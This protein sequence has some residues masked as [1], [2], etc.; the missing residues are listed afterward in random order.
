MA[1]VEEYLRY[2]GVENIR[3][4]DIDFL[5]ELHSKH[6]LKIP[7]ENLDIRFGRRIEIS[8]EAF[9]EKIL[10]RKR[11]GFCYELN[12]AFAWLLEQLGFTLSRLSARVGR[13]SGGY[14]PEFDHLTLLVHLDEDYLAD[15]GFGTSS[16]YP[17]PLSGVPVESTI[18]PYRIDRRE[19]DT[20][21]YQTLEEGNWKDLYFFTLTPHTLAEYAGMCAYHQENPDSPFVRGTILCTKATATG[22]VW[23]RGDKFIEMT[24]AGQAE[25]E[26]D[27]PERDR[28][29]H[30]YFAI[31]VTE[32]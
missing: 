32:Q 5:R 8:E 16:L 11:G 3:Q 24:A 10:R 2:I 27:I 26:I 29:L 23:V 6:L 30:E 25:R 28:L 1:S 20:Y 12:G 15:V 9:I 7:F 22:R 18:R 4:P 21:Y 17:V 31:D 19:N 13:A 14:G